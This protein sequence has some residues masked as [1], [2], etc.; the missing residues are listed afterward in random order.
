MTALDQVLK[1][2]N[3]VIENDRS[4][5]EQA[6]SATKQTERSQAEMLLSNLAKTAL[7]GTVKWNKN[8]HR[9]I[10]DAIASIDTMISRQLSVIMHDANFQQID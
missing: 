8:L 4:L 5:L 10:N 3:L 9:T 6:I 1:Q 7:K 2:E